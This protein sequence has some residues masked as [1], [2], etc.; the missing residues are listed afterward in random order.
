MSSRYL[1]GRI[2]QFSKLYGAGNDQRRSARLPVRC[3]HACIQGQG[4]SRTPVGNGR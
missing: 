2:F 4:G 3:Q 1:R